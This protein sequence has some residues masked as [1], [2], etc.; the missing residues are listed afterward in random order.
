MSEK[1]RPLG[2]I[3][4]EMEPLMNE[5]MDH[6]IQWADFLALMHVWLMVHRPGDRETYTAGG[7]PEFYYGPKRG[8]K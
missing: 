5:A 4:L 2:E 6:G 1:L 7:S 8:K 3:L